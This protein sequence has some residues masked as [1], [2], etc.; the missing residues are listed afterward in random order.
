M[1]SK[2]YEKDRKIKKNGQAKKAQRNV[3]P[4]FFM[5]GALG[6]ILLVAAAFFG[7]EIVFAM[8]DD[9]RCGDVVAVNPEELD[10]TSFNT[11][12][13]TDL[14]KRLTRFA[15]GLAAGDQY[16]VTVQDM[17]VTPELT[18]WMNEKKY[19]ED[20]QNLTW[21]LGVL[22]EEQ[23]DDYQVLRWQRC[24]IYGDDFA[25]GVNFILWY[26]ELGIDDEPMVRLLTD[27]ETGAIYGVRTNFES[28]AS[29]QLQISERL[30][31]EFSGQ[32]SESMWELCFS[33]AET[34]GGIELGELW[35][36]MSDVDV[37]EYIKTEESSEVDIGYWDWEQ[38]RDGYPEG[39]VWADEIYGREELQR[40]LQ[41]LSWQAST[42]ESD[43][44]IHWE[45][46]FPYGESRLAFRMYSGGAVWSSPKLRGSWFSNMTVGFPEIYER[47]PAFME[48]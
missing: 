24:V 42:F 8:Q 18:E 23:M 5:G 38:A 9:I 34:F 22:P 25:G 36:W 32:Y 15:E 17:E 33:L 7:P 3:R 2:Q 11:G 4:I 46:F 35:K 26:L 10:I 39:R 16:Y 12:Y 29:V 43:G 40:L 19:E 37:S 44:E 48:N 47:I 20:M 1:G 27:G 45:F 30:Y 14:Y 41:G 28:V 13:E 31:L 6:V 21:S